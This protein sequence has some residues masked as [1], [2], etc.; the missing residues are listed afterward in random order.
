MKFETYLRTVSIVRRITKDLTQVR[1]TV[2]SDH[3]KN[4][5]LVAFTRMRIGL[6]KGE[7]LSESPP[8]ASVAHVSEAKGR[9]RA[10]NRHFLDFLRRALRDHPA[11]P[12][13]NPAA[14]EF[15]AIKREV[16]VTQY[17]R[18]SVEYLPRSGPH[19]R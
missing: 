2:Y 16:E 14:T 18:L 8:G 19:C 13:I 5:M 1:V 15:A 6:H 7:K 12:H 9:K 11:C 10:K 3:P 17:G 4:R